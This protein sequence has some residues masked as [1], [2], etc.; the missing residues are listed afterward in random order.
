MQS[1]DLDDILQ[2]LA[3]AKYALEAHD[4]AAAAAAIDATLATVRR[5]M[6]AQ[7][8]SDDLLRGRPSNP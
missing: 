6:S 8:R 4:A 2:G 1:E 7:V 3:V 5:V